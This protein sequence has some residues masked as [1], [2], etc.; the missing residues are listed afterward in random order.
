[1]THPTTARQLTPEELSYIKQRRGEEPMN[2]IR[3]FHRNLLVRFTTEI[4]HRISPN[5]SGYI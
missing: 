3:A 2:Q 1:M 4:R 5:V